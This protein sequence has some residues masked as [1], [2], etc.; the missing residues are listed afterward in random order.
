MLC[1]VFAA[2]LAPL[3][4]C[5][6]QNPQNNQNAL[7]RRIGQATTIAAILLLA[8]G[9]AMLPPAWLQPA[10]FRHICSLLARS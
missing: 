6:V 8:V 3:G 4:L 9:L 10:S 7:I 1:C 2:L 5:A